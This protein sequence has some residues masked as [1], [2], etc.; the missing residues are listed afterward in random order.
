M[1]FNQYD[2]MKFKFKKSN[3][4]AKQG[5]YMLL[6]K[7]KSFYRELFGLAAPMALS[8]LVTFL[9]TLS[10]SIM[11]GRLSEEATASIYVGSLAATVLQ[12]LI[13]GFESGMTVI[14]TQ[15]FGR[16]ENEK[17]K[18]IVSIGTVLIFS[19][20]LIFSAVSIA[21]GSGITSIF[22][23][24]ASERSGAEYLATLSLSFPLFALSGAIVAA[25]RCVESVNIGVISSASAL[26]TNLLFNY[27]LIF[28]KLGFANLGIKGAA[29]ATII[30]RAVELSILLIY[31]FF[32][33]KRLK[34]KPTSF[35][36][37]NKKM[38]LEFIKYTSPIV[39]GQIIWIINTL[40]SS[41]VIS[42]SNTD[43]TVAAFS[44]A[45]TLGSLSYI[46]MNGLSAAVGIIIGK[47]IGENRLNKIREYTYS[48]EIIFVILGIVT[49]LA[50]FLAKNPFVSIYNVSEGAKDAAKSL[51]TVLGFTVIGTSYQS[52]S[53]MG[54]V[55]GGGDV[56]FIL[57]ND[58]FFIF[59]VVIPASVAA[60]RLDA[61]LWV[62]FLMLKS[63]QILIRSWRC[64]SR[65]WP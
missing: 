36:K 39:L 53:L 18:R 52:A 20:G 47:T 29:I 3:N 7:D 17:I 32:I 59:L 43:A 62:I 46:V 41:Y 44:I 54:I 37:F 31:A 49:S 58:A 45:N 63:D 50:L 65:S 35:F 23:S 8:N 9:I 34:L 33:D 48:T 16:G 56:S 1:F 40:F 6:T 11:I 19:V 22:L 10:D 28:G 64:R 27:L 4:S 42:L 25:M 13:T 2:F 57:K 30:A 61:P 55:R 21:F 15:Y 38:N 26:I 14:G 60:L 24:G 5:A 51:I 12:M